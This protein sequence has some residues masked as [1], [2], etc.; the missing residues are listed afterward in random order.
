MSTQGMPVSGNEFDFG[1]MIRESVQVLTAPQAF[2]AGMARTGGLI[3]PVIRTV[4]FG[5]AAAVINLVWSFVPIGLVSTGYRMLGGFVGLIAFP[6]LI[7]VGLFIGAAILLV[8]S[9]ICGGSTDYTFCVRITGVLAV[10]APINALLGI[11]SRVNLYLGLLVSL[12][13]SFYSLWLLY[14]ALVHAL[15]GKAAVAKIIALVLAAISILFSLGGLAMARTASR[16]S[17]GLA[18][19]GEQFKDFQKAMEAMKKEMEKGQKENQ[20]EEQPTEEEQPGEEP[21]PAE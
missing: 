3:D 6:I 19:E 18:K 21:A 4:I 7:L 20:E 12:A 17:E 9:A 10:M 1:R 11:A 16:F 14:N 2:F 15:G 5:F 8:C 13:V